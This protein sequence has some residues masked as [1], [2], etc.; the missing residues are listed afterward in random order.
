M[1]IATGIIVGL[2]ITAVGGVLAWLLGALLAGIATHMV[3]TAKV[4]P[5]K[6]A[7]AGVISV[8]GILILVAGP[9]TSL[10]GGIAAA[11]KIIGG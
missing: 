3:A 7:G 9:F 4:K 5:G 2:L 11:V 10:W 6:A 8:I 1:T